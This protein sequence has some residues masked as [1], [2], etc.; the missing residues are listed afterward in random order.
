MNAKEIVVSFFAMASIVLL[1]ANASASY[2]AGDGV[3]D[4]SLVTVNDA[5]ADSDNAAVIAGE[6]L[7][8]KVWFTAD[9]NDTDVTIEAEIE[10]EK[11]DTEARTESFDVE[12]NKIYRKTL[13]IKVPYELKDQIS[14]DVTLSIEI[15]GAE[16][17][18]TYEYVLR[19]QRPSYNAEVK[20]V[21][22]AN[23]LSAGETFPVDLVIKNRG[24]NELDDLYVK[25]SVPALG[26]E[27]STYVGD[28]VAVEYCDDDC[29]DDEEDTVSGR[30]Y[31]TVPYNAQSGIY[32]LEVEVS[33]DDT[34]SSV[35]KQIA[36]ENSFPSNVIATTTKKSVSV[37][38]DAEYKILL[39]NPTNTLKVYNVMT[40]SS[41][42]LTSE[43]LET[44]V[45]V[46]AGSSKEVTVKASAAT[47]GTYNFKV[48][49]L[50]NDQV[51]GSAT[52]VLETEGSK[53]L[54]AIVIL[55]I[56]LAIIFVV[57]LVVLIVLLGKKP[58]KT[59]EFGESYY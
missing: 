56:V 57:L 48:N 18:D 45:A 14:D 2:V 4:I 42:D 41:S 43:A 21:T 33:N 26:L 20:S 16:F 27:K 51:M 15:D 7:T 36:I 5:S 31:L 22:V 52:L 46:P 12:G 39:V 35:V 32:A 1:L 19:V 50:S 58:E 11:V 47:E 30:L 25:I 24:Y 23:K 49:V 44:V 54:S 10:G 37:G 28:L 9:E 6:T 8:L 34:T 53:A 29:D 3:Y 59:E 13:S 38:E 55:T 17:K 40:E